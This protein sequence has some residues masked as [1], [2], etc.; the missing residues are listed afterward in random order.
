M[1]KSIIP[2][3]P[4]LRM[5]VPTLALA[6]L[7]LFT[8]CDLFGSG[9]KTAPTATSGGGSGTT[10][11]SNTLS[12][13]GTASTNFPEQQ[14]IVDVV[15]RARPAVV[16]VVNKLDPSQSGF[17]GEALGT[18]MIVDTKGDIFTNNHVIAGAAPGGLS[19][20]LSNGDKVAATLVG[21][22]D[23]S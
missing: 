15:N 19:V 20:I 16:T 1:N 17:G 23:V 8:G 14:A 6:I 22:D 10:S 12:T 5:A 3:R 21:A 7:L 4:R 11:T 18:G 13:A 9:D 2:A